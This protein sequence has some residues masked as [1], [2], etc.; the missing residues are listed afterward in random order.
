[1]ASEN[2]TSSNTPSESPS[3]QNTHSS[4]LYTV[5]KKITDH[6][7]EQY[8]SGDT[9]SFYINRIAD[10]LETMN[11]ATEEELLEVFKI[12]EIPRISV[13]EADENDRMDNFTNLEEPQGENEQYENN[14]QEQETDHEEQMENSPCEI[15][16]EEEEFPSMIGNCG[17]PCDGYCQ[18]CDPYGNSRYGRYDCG[19][20]ESGYCDY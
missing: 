6:L 1:M 15:Y 5:F 17:F 4:L 9:V 12:L 14:D 11:E 16:N 19:W 18:T 8:K 13:V 7:Y 2:I 10:K 20:N 3:V